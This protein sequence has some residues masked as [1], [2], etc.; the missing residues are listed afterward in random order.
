MKLLFG[1]RQT[2]RTTN[3]IKLFLK[4]D[5]GRLVVRNLS[6][7]ERIMKLC[8]ASA[9]CKKP[10][11]VKRIITYA[12]YIKPDFLLDSSMKTPNLYIDDLLDLVAQVLKNPFFEYKAAT[13]LGS[14]NKQEIL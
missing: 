1:K 5:N 12:N 4:D 3:L 11:L 2:G 7:K 8:R 13:I 10:D 9:L 14:V 6:E